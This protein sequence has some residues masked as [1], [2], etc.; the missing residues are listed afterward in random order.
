MSGSS[1]VNSKLAASIL[2]ASSPP[3]SGI[4]ITAK[5]PAASASTPSN[6]SAF[7]LKLRLPEIVKFMEAEQG[8]TPGWLVLG[9]MDVGDNLLAISSD[10]VSAVLWDSNSNQ[11]HLSTRND[12]VLA[13]DCSALTCP[14]LGWQRRVVFALLLGLI[15]RLPLPFAAWP[16]SSPAP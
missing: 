5:S 2:T 6:V 15:D 8:T 4:P 11:L 9:G 12:G 1:P 3:S 13:L 16:A 10:D 14:V 7:A